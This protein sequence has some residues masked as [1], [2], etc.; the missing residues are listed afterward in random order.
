MKII[1]FTFGRRLFMDA[2]LPEKDVA[3]VDG[4]YGLHERCEQSGA[5]RI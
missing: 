1:N 2:A 3:C 4:P 5:G